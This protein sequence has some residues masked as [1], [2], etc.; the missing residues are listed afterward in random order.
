[1]KPNLQQTAFITH[2]QG[3][4]FKIYG[5]SWSFSLSA[6]SCSVFTNAEP[7]F[8]PTL[9][10][11]SCNTRVICGVEAKPRQFSG[12]CCHNTLL[13]PAQQTLE[14]SF[15]M[16]NIHKQ[17]FLWGLRVCFSCMCAC[18]FV[19]SQWVSP[20][21]LLFLVEKNAARQNSLRVCFKKWD[22]P[23]CGY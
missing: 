8:M 11:F 13:P 16:T 4:F 18:A 3:F 22:V 14:V 2:K 23:G 20:H 12:Q 21:S 1:M 10:S 19:G 17:Y 7:T 15:N 5:N 9:I 6:A